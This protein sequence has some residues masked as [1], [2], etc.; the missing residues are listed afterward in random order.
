MVDNV[1]LGED[2]Y[3]GGSM[4]TTMMFDEGVAGLCGHVVVYCEYMI[5]V[6]FNSP[7]E[8]VDRLQTSHGQESGACARVCSGIIVSGACGDVL[9]TK[10]RLL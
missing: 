9:L 6:C 2:V 8:C 5:G 10:S 4:L 7:I 1:V 3:V